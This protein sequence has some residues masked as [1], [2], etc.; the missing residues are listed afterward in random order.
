MEETMPFYF[1]FF[2]CGFFFNICGKF[3]EILGNKEKHFSYM[4]NITPQNRNLPDQGNQDNCDHA[5]KHQ[6]YI[7]L[8][9]LHFLL[10]F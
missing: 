1:L 4:K 3:S 6:S 5:C 9:Q 10:Y 2:M 7:S 8:A